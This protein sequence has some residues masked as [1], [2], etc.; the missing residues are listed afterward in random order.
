MNDAPVE[1]NQQQAQRN[2]VVRA[3]LELE[4]IASNSV[5]YMPG[6]PR[7]KRKK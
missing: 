4:L 3:P 5:C 1:S 7:A 6:G 2:V